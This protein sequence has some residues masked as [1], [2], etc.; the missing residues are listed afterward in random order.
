M[1]TNESAIDRVI[2]VV[3]GLALASLIP[4]KVATGVAA[5]AV[6]VAAAIALVTGAVGICAIYALFGLST[7]KA[8]A[9]S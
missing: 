9:K 5:I 2:R 3:L 7:A 4:L 8:R 1:K 6:G